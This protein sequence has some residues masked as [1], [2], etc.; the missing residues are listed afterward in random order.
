MQILLSE[1]DIPL[2]AVDIPPS[3]VDIPPSEVDTL[4]KGMVTIRKDLGIPSPKGKRDMKEMKD[5]GMK[6]MGI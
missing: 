2:S 1:A 6:D 5:M 4:L 3:A